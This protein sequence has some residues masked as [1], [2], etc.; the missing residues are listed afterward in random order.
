MND[1]LSLVPEPLRNLLRHR[2]RTS[3]TVMGITIGIFALVV[4]GALAEKVNQLVQGGEEYLSN[5]IAITDKGGG[6]PFFGG[7]GL[8]PL[9]FAESVRQVPGV[10]CV[11]TSINL[12]LDPE[13]GASVGMP[14]IISG[15]VVDEV[16][17]C[18]RVA[19]SSVELSFA[20]GDWWRQGER[21]VT[22]LGADVAERLKARVGQEVILRD[23]PFRVVGILN[24]TL[25]GPDN[26]AYVPLDDARELLRESRL[27]FSEIDL[28][29]KVDTIFAAVQPGV[30]G[31]Q[32]ARE[33]EARNP[34][35]RAFGPSELKEPLQTSNMVFQFIIL[36]VAMIALIVGGLSVINTMVMS[37]AERVREIGIKKAVGASDGDIL[38]E[39]LAEAIAIGALGGLLGLLAG[40]LAVTV[41]NDFAREAAGGPIFLVTGRLAIGSVAFATF[42]GAVA[43]LL[44]AFRAARL[45]PVEALRAE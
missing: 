35:I 44:P 38:R 33:I 36:G 24:R 3:L 21:G 11:E 22:V 7:F 28:S 1:L 39:Y 43:G 12:L 9:S 34:D 10:A 5:R 45:R 8:V 13:G 20:R 41:L 6:H 4:L 40:S 42:L 30:D 32:L 31:D 29:D 16:Q 14:Q 23:H 17:Q 19:P 37:V 26:I 2:L 15:V 25:T 27:F 18:D